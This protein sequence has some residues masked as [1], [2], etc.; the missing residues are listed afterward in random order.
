[1][2]IFDHLSAGTLF[3]LEGEFNKFSTKS[4]HTHDCHQLLRIRSGTSLLEEQTLQQP[5]FSNYTAVIPAGV[6]HRSLVLEGPVHYKSI[7]LD[8]HVLPSPG[9]AIRI[10]DM[11]PLGTA[12]FDRI[13]LGMG[14]GEPNEFH[15]KCL[16][17]L[18]TIVTREM[19][20]SADITRIPRQH[21]GRTG[22]SPIP[23]S[24]PSDVVFFHQGITPGPGQA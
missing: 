15:L 14:G 22:P 5:L 7:Y 17:L 21:S 4:L 9:K 18:L 12:L 8:Q 6:P 3:T 19:V 20:F 2:D 1:M 23:I 13:E 11:S 16:D 10:F 24:S